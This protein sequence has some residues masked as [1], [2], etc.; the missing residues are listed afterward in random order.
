MRGDRAHQVLPNRPCV[1]VAFGAVVGLVLTVCCHAVEPSTADATGLRAVTDFALCVSC[2]EVTTGRTDSSKGFLLDASSNHNTC[3]VVPLDMAK[4]TGPMRVM[5]M[6]L[7]AGVPV[8]DW[9]ISMF[10]LGYEMS[11]LWKEPMSIVPVAGLSS[12]PSSVNVEASG[13]STRS[14]LASISTLT[15]DAPSEGLLW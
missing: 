5:V 8:S 2:P 6:K 7:G 9:D 12:E 15:T 4:M 10:K 11:D 14:P 13:A 1:S 3:E